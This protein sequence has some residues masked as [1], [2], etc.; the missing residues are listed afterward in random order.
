MFVSSRFQGKILIFLFDYD[1]Q[2]FSAL[3]D[4]GTCQFN[5]VNVYAPNTFTGHKLFFQNLHRYFLSP[6]CIIAGDFNCVHNKLVRL[7]IL[8]D[9]LPDK[10]IVCRFLLDCLTDFWH[11]QHPRGTSYTWANAYYSKASR[12]DCF[13]VSHLL[14]DCIECPKV[15]PCSFSDHDFVTLIFFP[16]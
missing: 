2:I 5:L 7:H 4:F 14:E 6:S 16:G 8:N 13:L 1:G 11:K 3:I 12:L 9:S 10:S 15:F